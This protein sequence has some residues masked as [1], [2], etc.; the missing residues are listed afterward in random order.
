MSG[1]VPPHR[2]VSFLGPVAEF[3]GSDRAVCAREAD[4]ASHETGRHALRDRAHRRASGAGRRPVRA[5]RSHQGGPKGARSG[6]T[7]HE[8]GGRG[9]RTI[10][11]AL[12]A[13][14][15]LLVREAP[16]GWAERAE[17]WVPPRSGSRRQGEVSDRGDL[18]PGSR[19]CGGA[20]VAARPGSPLSV[21]VAR[22]CRRHHHAPRS[23]LTLPGDFGYRP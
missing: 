12:A 17:L 20:L 15:A 8:A 5:T 1:L 21:P 18:E 10:G 16:G 14:V 9:G 3:S 23:R 13:P 6:P 22:P 4:T 11:R 2:R 7:F 19:T